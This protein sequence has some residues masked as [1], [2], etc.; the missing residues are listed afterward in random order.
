LHLHFP[1]PYQGEGRGEVFPPPD[2]GGQRGG[3]P[4]KKPADSLLVREPAE[5]MLFFDSK[6]AFHHPPFFFTREIIK[7]SSSIFANFF[8]TCSA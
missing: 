7:C 1:S 3:S 2:K 4:N 8:I 5:L 6:T